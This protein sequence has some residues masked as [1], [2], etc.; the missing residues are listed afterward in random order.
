M[1]QWSHSKTLLDLHGQGARGSG[2]TV[3]VF[4]GHVKSTTSECVFVVEAVRCLAMLFPLFQFNGGMSSD[5]GSVV[6]KTKEPM[7]RA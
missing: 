1:R 2:F 4:G 6:E 3:A 5:E 7:H